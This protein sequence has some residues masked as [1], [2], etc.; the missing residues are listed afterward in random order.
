MDEFIILHDNNSTK[1]GSFANL[2]QYIRKHYSTKNF[3]SIIELL[4]NSSSYNL[5][6]YEKTMVKSILYTTNK[7][8]SPL[9][10]GVITANRLS[11][12]VENWGYYEIIL[13]GN[14]VRTIK[15][16]SYFLLTIEML[17]KLYLFNIK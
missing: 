1:T 12:K 7:K 15:Y 17:K 14:C 8:F 13:L 5:G 4:S 9:G 3:D 11:F 10:R 6:P 2:V 16:N